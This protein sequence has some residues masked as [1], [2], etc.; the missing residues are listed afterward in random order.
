MNTIMMVDELESLGR[1]IK[2]LEESLDKSQEIIRA[3]QDE[4]SWVREQFAGMMSEL[5]IDPAEVRALH[6]TMSEYRTKPFKR[7]VDTQVNMEEEE[8]STVPSS[9]QNHDDFLRVLRCMGRE[10]MESNP[11]VGQLQRSAESSVIWCGIAKDASLDFL[12]YI[13]ELCNSPAATKIMKGLLAAKENKGLV[14]DLDDPKNKR[15]GDYD[16]ELE[17]TREARRSMS[18]IASLSARKIDPHG[19][20]PADRPTAEGSPPRAS[21][22]FTMDDFQG[23]PDSRDQQPDVFDSDDEADAVSSMKPLLDQIVYAW[24]MIGKPHKFWANLKNHLRKNFRIKQSSADSFYEILFSRSMEMSEEADLMSKSKGFLVRKI[25]KLKGKISQSGTKV[26]ELDLER[27][28][29]RI[30]MQDEIIAQKEVLIRDR[31]AGLDTEQ[32]R[33]RDELQKTIDMQKARILGMED[34][35]KELR[36]ALIS[37]FDR[38]EGAKSEVLKRRAMSAVPGTRIPSSVIEQ[39]G[40]GA[41]EVRKSAGGESGSGAREELTTLAYAP[42]ITTQRDVDSTSG[43]AQVLELTNSLSNMRRGLYEAQAEN[44]RLKKQASSKQRALESRVKELEGLLEDFRR[45]Q[46]ANMAESIAAAATEKLGSTLREKY[47]LQAQVEELSADLLRERTIRAKNNQG[48]RETVEEVIEKQ[49]FDDVAV[50]KRRYDD[51]LSEI[52]LK[53]ASSSPRKSK[54]KSAAGSR[55][56]TPDVRSS[57]A[58]LSIDAS[59]RTLHSR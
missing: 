1:D 24:N 52:R 54:K 2:I 16:E 45:S 29:E 25:N 39:H 9:M 12:A 4:L 26:D 27:L 19:G 30:R 50:V 43:V 17:K 40:V 34:V 10:I 48:W 57:S 8:V 59:R 20:S 38:A 53:L 11:T 3:Q 47:L 13:L 42:L 15:I 18:R 6:A 7:E 55:G 33:L 44:I 41:T 32:I 46:A 58:K 14:P 23:T 5:D 49:V 37:Q 22:G 31:N 35:I 21:S 56:A 51:E 36:R 28:R